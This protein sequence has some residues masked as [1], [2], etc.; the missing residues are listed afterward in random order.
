M[1]QMENFWNLYAILK[2]WSVWKLFM[3]NCWTPWWR[4][5]N[6][7]RAKIFIGTNRKI[8][9]EVRRSDYGKG[10][11]K[12]EKMLSDTKIKFVLVN[13]LFSCILFL[14]LKKESNYN[15]MSHTDDYMISFTQGTSSK[16]KS[17]LCKIQNFCEKYNLHMITLT[18]NKY[19]LTLI[20]PIQKSFG[21]RQNIISLY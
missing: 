10:N 4:I 12:I 16:D 21:W 17:T 15:K 11:N 7:S 14:C 9:N 1:I 2:H 19:H 20:K 3:K 6:H 5:Y 18:E 8:F 13:C